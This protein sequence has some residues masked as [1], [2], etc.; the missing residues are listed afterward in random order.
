[1]KQRGED[2]KQVMAEEGS[3][4]RRRPVRA[5]DLERKRQIRRVTQLLAD[6]NCDKRTFMAVLREELGHPDGSPMF[7]KY[8][9]AWDEFR[10]PQ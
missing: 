7:L 6:R 3:R 4:G 9:K 1:M 10:G 5:E 8:V 2:M